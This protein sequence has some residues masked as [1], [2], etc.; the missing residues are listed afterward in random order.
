M[1]RI[2][3]CFLQCVSPD[4]DVVRLLLAC[5]SQEALDTFLLLHHESGAEHSTLVRRH[6]WDQVQ[7][8][9]HSGCTMPG[10]GTLI[11]QVFLSLAL[12]NVLSMSWCESPSS[13]WSMELISVVLGHS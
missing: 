2:T 7:E 13:F 9:L 3:L 1:K 4:L 10:G 8:L 5:H 12:M 6:V 11:H